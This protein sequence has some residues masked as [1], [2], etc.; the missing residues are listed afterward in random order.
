MATQ[1]V[2][3][4]ELFEERLFLR[5][6]IDLLP[7]L[8]SVKD[9]AGKN[10]WVN[11]AKLKELGLQDVKEIIG[12]T[13]FDFFRPR[14]GGKFSPRRRTGDANRTAGHQSLLWKK[15]S[16]RV[17]PKTLLASH[18]LPRFRGAT[19]A[20][21]SPGVMSISRD[22]T[23]ETQAAIKLDEKTQSDSHAG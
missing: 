3:P 22:I 13:S 15:S 23:G 17:A 5:A 11:R 19:P 6:V 9:R 2:S 1:P 10:V 20:G 16:S 14:D 8:V 12:K 21:T 4:A 18:P 7:D